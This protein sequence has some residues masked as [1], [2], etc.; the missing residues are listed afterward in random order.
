MQKWILGNWKMH[1]RR[2]QIADFLLA[3][4]SDERF[5]TM[6]HVW[7]GVAFPAVFLAGAA[8]ALQELGLKL[9]AQ[10]VSEF[11]KDGAFTGEVSAQ[12]LRDVGCSWTLVGHSERRQNAKE[13]G[14]NLAKKMHAAYDADLVPVLCVGESLEDR[15][16]GKMF[17]CVR[18][19]I[20]EIAAVCHAKALE[21]PDFEWV[22]AYEPIWAIGTGLTPSLDEVS[23]ML[24][25]I[26]QAAAE[27]FK[28]LNSTSG[29]VNIRALYG[30]SVKPENAADLLN[31]E[32][33]DG[34]LVGG[35][36]L[37]AEDFSAICFALLS[38]KS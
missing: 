26:K 6:P 22:I 12:M 28:G 15:Q 36:S 1:G 18:A 31:L 5:Q 17:D 8:P 11:A 9:G 24:R 30:G 16:A 21:K 7:F 23:E 33:L 3:L 2:A 38:K 37:K 32:A 4:A 25:F 27:S 35:A 13:C 10:D 20:Q 14:K 19:Q 29:Y 34:L